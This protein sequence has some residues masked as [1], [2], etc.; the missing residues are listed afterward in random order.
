MNTSNDKYHL[1]CIYF[2]PVRQ[3]NFMVLPSGII[4]IPTIFQIAPTQKN[5]EYFF[6]LPMPTLVDCIHNFKVIKSAQERSGDESITVYEKCEM[7]GY[8]KIK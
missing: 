1:D 6:K 3:Q 5:M 2:D 8:I 7:C 4:S